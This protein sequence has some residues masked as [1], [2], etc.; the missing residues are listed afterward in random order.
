M[1]VI[2]D[3]LNND[4]GDISLAA[5]GNTT[6]DDLTLG[7]N[8]DITVSGN[9]GFIELVAGGDIIFGTNNTVTTAGGNIDILA[10]TDFTVAGNVPHVV[11]A[12][13]VDLDMTDTTAINSNNG[14]INLQ[15]TR[16][17]T[18]GDVDAG[19]G[20]ISV[21]ADFDN[22]T[23]GAIIDGNNATVNLTGNTAT[24]IAA[25]GIGSGNAI[26]TQ[27][28]TGNATN[29][30]NGNIEITEVAAGGNLDVANATLTGAAGDDIRIST[31]GGDLNVIAGG[32][33]V[34]I[35]DTGTAAARIFL[36]AGGAGSDLNVDDVITTQGG[37]I[38]LDAANEYDQSAVNVTSGGNGAG[39]EIDITDIGGI[40][41]L[42]AGG[43]ISSTGNVGFNSGNISIAT[44]GAGASNVTIAGT[45]NASSQNNP[46]GA[47]GNGGN[48]T[49]STVGD[50]ANII[51]FGPGTINVNGGAGTGDVGGNAG[52]ITLTVTGNATSITA[53]IL[54]ALGGNSD[55]SGA[56][57]GGNILITTADGNI[58]TAA[59]TTTGGEDTAAGNGGTGGNV[60][61]SGSGT[62]RTVTIGGAITALGG[63]SSTGIG[64]DGGNVAIDTDG[65]G[66]ATITV[67]NNGN[68]DI[69]TA[70]LT[71]SM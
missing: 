65:G 5:D 62:G 47:A 21:T 11:G 59:I 16:D 60:T 71:P 12:A 55:G 13:N 48:V 23:D 67:N 24:L 17:V 28:T 6:A 50:G 34:T 52:D 63:D 20:D 57:D 45:V 43:V 64:G 19:T 70:A 30:G 8:V 42:A 56:G 4:G 27:I 58:T 36:S 51:L 29:S 49:V 44:T 53:P 18:L 37:N 3:V 46:G 2:E 9:I 40:F 14:D 15:A 7:A 61:I 26:E 54:T 32:A 38:D 41:D 31:L 25:T 68:G 66:A 35:T 1:T 33:G 69:T 22:A 39:G 10:G